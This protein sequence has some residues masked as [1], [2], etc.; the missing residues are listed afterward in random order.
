MGVLYVSDNINIL[1][2]RRVILK[3]IKVNLFA[4]V[5]REKLRGSVDKA[6]KQEG[7]YEFEGDNPPPLHHLSAAF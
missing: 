2:Y 5:Q 1:G 6:K 3:A 4:T 7:A